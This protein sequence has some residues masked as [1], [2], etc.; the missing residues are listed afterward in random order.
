MSVGVSTSVH[1]PWLRHCS[2][3]S[4]RFIEKLN[5]VAM[6]TPPPLPCQ[7]LGTLYGRSQRVRYRSWSS[8]VSVRRTVAD[9]GSDATVAWRSRILFLTLRQLLFHG[10]K[11]LLMPEEWFGPILPACPAPAASG[12]AR[13]GGRASTGSA[14][15]RTGGTHSKSAESGG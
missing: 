13:V 9:D 10:V 7:F 3:T 2:G 14:P 12:P 11:P 1:H 15:D 6:R 4:L 8:H 5:S